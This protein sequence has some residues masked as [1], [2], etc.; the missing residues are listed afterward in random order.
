MQLLTA[1]ILL[2]LQTGH[3]QR[4]IFQ[5]CRLAPEAQSHFP[6]Q[7]FMA[8]QWITT[9]EFSL[10]MQTLRFRAVR[11]HHPRSPFLHQEHIMYGSDCASNA[12]DG[13][14]LYTLHSLSI[15]T[16]QHQQQPHLSLLLLMFAKVNY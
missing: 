4:L 13:V 10:P 16:R 8:L 5:V 6:H 2:K 3:Y 7:D 14:N 9:G 12:A 11:L 1:A 15:T